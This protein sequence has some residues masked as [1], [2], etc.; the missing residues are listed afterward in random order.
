[1]TFLNHPSLPA[2]FMSRVVIGPAIVRGIEALLAALARGE[3]N[4]GDGIR[5]SVPR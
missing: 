4:P 5:A 1:M 3:V 2:I